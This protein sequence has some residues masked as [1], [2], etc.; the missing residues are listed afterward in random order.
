[1][2]ISASEWRL[3]L[4]SGQPAMARTWFSNWLTAQASMVQC[5]LLW[6]RGAIS[7]T[8]SRAGRRVIRAQV[9]QLDGEHA[10]VVQRWAMLA[11]I[12]RARTRSAAGKP[13]GTDERSR[14][15]AWCTLLGQS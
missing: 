2:V 4:P 1:L 12:S 14:M 5:P 8:R 9:E 3:V 7:L 15:P 11:P 13:D 10:H 6:T